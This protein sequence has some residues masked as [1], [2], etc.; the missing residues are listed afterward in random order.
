MKLAAARIPALL[1]DPSGIDAALIYGEDAGLVRER[2]DALAHAVLGPTP[3]PFR[4]AELGD[5]APKRLAEEATA[6]ALTGG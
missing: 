5:D 1:R 3:D 6:R 2:A 4:L